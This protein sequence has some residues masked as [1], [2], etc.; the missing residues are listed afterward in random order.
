MEITVEEE[1]KDKLMKIIEDN[2]RNLQDNNKQTLKLQRLQKE[3][4]MYKK[5]F[6]EIIVKNFPN[7]GKEIATLV[8]ESQRVP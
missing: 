4:K 7:M 6:D 5:I 8:Q 2:L 3:K 1:N